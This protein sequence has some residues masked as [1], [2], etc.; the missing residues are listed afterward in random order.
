MLKAASAIT[1]SAV[2][3]IETAKSAATVRCKTCIMQRIPLQPATI[4]IVKK[5][6]KYN[7]LEFN[8]KIPHA[9]AATGDSTKNAS[10]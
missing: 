1:P 3:I 7:R 10:L 2:A 5:G 6:C 9:P 4:D 8:R